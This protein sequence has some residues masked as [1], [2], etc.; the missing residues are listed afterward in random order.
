MACTTE[1]TPPFPVTLKP[2][3]GGGGPRGRIVRKYYVEVERCG[4]AGK[5]SFKTEVKRIG[6]KLETT[7]GTIERDALIGTTTSTGFIILASLDE[8][9][10]TK[11]NTIKK[12]IRQAFTT[13]K[14]FAIGNNLTNLE[15][16]LFLNQL[17]FKNNDNEEQINQENDTTEGTY[18]ATDNKDTKLPVK[19]EEN[20]DPYKYNFSTIDIEIKG[21]RRKSYGNYY[22]PDDLS[23]NR[24][25]RVR[26]TQ[27]YTEG[28]KIEATIDA[29]AKQ[30]QRKK[31][32]ITGSVTLPIVTGIED[33]NRVDWQGAT[34]NPIQ[35]LGASGALGVF[36]G[37]AEGQ[38]VSEVFSNAAGA[39]SAA[40]AKMGGKGAGA[41]SDIRNAINVYLAQRAVGAQGLLS[42]ATG[43][44]LNPNLEMLFGGPSL[45]NFAFTFTLSP[46]DADEADQV[47]K[48]IRFFKQGMSVKTTASNVFLKAPNV[49]DIQY[50]TFNTDGQ[51]IVHPSINIIKTC[52]LLS[53]NIQYTPNNTYM[54]YEDPFRT[55]TAYQMTLSFGE[56]DPIYDN[57]Y[58]DVDKNQ[59]QVIGY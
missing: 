29:G 7:A 53:C 4:T 18:L 28:T 21:D 50:Q 42:R 24:Q 47:R 43:A 34:L 25:D 6:T 40:S 44:V 38:G 8:I 51:E 31:S 48:I 3:S 36:Q 27:K 17:G 1:K 15:R 33:T 13:A 39:V 9:E 49:F 41:G 35:A 59:D 26:F 45:R 54:T 10:K 19:K 11:E 22:Y 20:D 16:T 55:M 2:G 46:R 30:F 37:I 57:D 14:N 58:T 23:S 52:A 5:Y 56:L 12:Q 32:K